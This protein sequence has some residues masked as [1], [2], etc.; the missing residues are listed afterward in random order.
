MRK[1]LQTTADP[2]E[3]PADPALRQANLRRIGRLFA[4]YRLRLSG[5]LLLIVGSAALGVV[6]AFLLKSVLEAIGGTTHRR[7]RSPP[8]G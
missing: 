5:L 8:A 2:P 6:P 3:R 1:F 7:C 4:P